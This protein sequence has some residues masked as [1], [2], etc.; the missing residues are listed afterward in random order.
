MKFIGWEKLSGDSDNLINNIT[1]NLDDPNIGAHL[2]L[3][4]NRYDFVQTP[5][6]Q[7]LLDTDKWPV[8]FS[9]A[10]PLGNGLEGGTN[11]PDEPTELEARNHPSLFETFPEGEGVNALSQLS[12]ILSVVEWKIGSLDSGTVNQQFANPSIVRTVLDAATQPDDET[13]VWDTPCPTFLG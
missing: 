2:F 10:F 11:T 3:L 13:G 9:A 4:D 5:S 6:D 12:S 7:E 8:P 1:A